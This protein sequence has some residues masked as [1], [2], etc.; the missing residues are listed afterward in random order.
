MG[1]TVA[2]E[3][4]TQLDEPVTT[5]DTESGEITVPFKDSNNVRANG[6]KAVGGAEGR[7]KE[8][9]IRYAAS[10]MQGWR[11]S[12]EDHH[13]L[14]P[15]ITIPP[16]SKQW[17]GPT[18]LRDHSLFAVF[19]GHG[20]NFTSRYAA[21]HM[22]SVLVARSEWAQYL[23]LS[24]RERGDVPG[25]ELLKSAMTGAFL[26]LDQELHSLHRGTAKCMSRASSERREEAEESDKGA[27]GGMLCAPVLLCGE[28]RGAG[29]EARSD[30]PTHAGPMSEEMISAIRSDRSGS[31]AV[32]VLL[33]PTHV[34]CAN[35]GDSRSILVRSG[36]AFPLSFDHKPTAASEHDRIVNA[37]GVVQMKRVDGDLAVSR[38]LGDFRFKSNLQLRADQQKVSARPDLIVSPRDEKGDEFI[39]VACDGIWDVMDNQDCAKVVQGLLD[40]GEDDLGRLCEEVLDICLEKDSR[41]N[42]TMAVVGLPGCR[43]MSKDEQRLAGK[44]GVAERR[45]ARARKGMTPGESRRARREAAK[46]AKMK[47]AKERAAKEVE[48]VAA[49]TLA[50]DEAAPGTTASPT[51]VPAP[52]LVKVSE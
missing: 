25:V 46:R 51:R 37:A 26:D 39:V 1:N 5:K 15:S 13:L 20:G 49:I 27:R 2:A 14:I 35:S 50:K 22:L 24:E 52:P 21:T 34:V 40:D 32:A 33:T 47:A 42:M 9:T 31:T 11:P 12:N 28:R 3:Q 41:D 17:K 48:A 29:G 18:T 4:Q 6:G 19:D 44:R 10:S 23:A 43:I 38:G 45:E 7:P 36:V 30:Q 16:P 8:N